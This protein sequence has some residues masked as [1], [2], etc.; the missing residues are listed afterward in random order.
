[1]ALRLN[2]QTSGYVELKAPAA[3]GSNT[4]TLPTSNGSSGQYLQTN[5]SGVLSWATVAT[6]TIA[7]ESYAIIADQKAAGTNAGTFTAGSWVTRELNTELADPD[8]IVSIAT[9]QFT[10]GA[11]SYLIKA[12]APAYQVDSHQVR[13]YNVTDTATA[14]VGYISYTNSSSGAQT[15]SELSGRITITDTKVFE[16]QHKS[17]GTKSNNGLGTGAD[18]GEPNLY[19]MVEIYKE[20]A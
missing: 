15:R 4:L 11:G 2:G 19:A 20:A 17:N 8:G 3:A 6:P 5:G 12:S 10:L 13:L 1:M 16:L 9:N 14:I 18:L 7:F